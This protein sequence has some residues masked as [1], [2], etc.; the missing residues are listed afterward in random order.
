MAALLALVRGAVNE[1]L[2]LPSEVWKAL[3]PAGQAPALA[4]RPDAEAF[5]TAIKPADEIGSL[6]GKYSRRLIARKERLEEE[7][8]TAEARRAIAAIRVKPT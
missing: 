7:F 3:W 1:E 2:M 4:S 8:N 6:R 5:S